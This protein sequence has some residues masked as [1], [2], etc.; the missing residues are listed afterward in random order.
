MFP[1]FFVLLHVRRLWSN[2]LSMGLLNLNNV[3][4]LIR[5]LLSTHRM[6]CI[7]PT[8]SDPT[9]KFLLTIFIH[10][11]PVATSLFFFF[12]F[13]SEFNEIWCVWTVVESLNMW[14]F[15]TGLKLLC[16]CKKKACNKVQAWTAYIASFSI[17][18]HERQTWK[19]DTAES[20]FRIYYRIQQGNIM[21]LGG[22]QSLE[23]PQIIK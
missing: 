15:I 2:V 4:L 19:R 5:L 10:L 1:K 3:M 20:L 23:V 7:D 14:K 16:S 21:G 6:F 8:P 22:E 12:L 18:R 11:F 17:D 13:K 9:Q